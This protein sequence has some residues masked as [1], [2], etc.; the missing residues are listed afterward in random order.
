[1][2]LTVVLQSIK[3]KSSENYNYDIYILHNKLDKSLTQKLINYIQAENFSIKF[4]DIS[5]IL[6]LL[7]VKSNFIQH[8]FL[9]KQH[10]IVFLFLKFLRI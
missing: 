3:E 9:V 5:R 2:Y 4:V 8:C 10:I 1:S 7:K 6:N